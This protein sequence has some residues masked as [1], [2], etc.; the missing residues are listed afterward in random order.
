MFLKNFFKDEKSIILSAIFSFIFLESLVFFAVE[1]A[2]KSELD[3]YL[4]VIS[5]DFKSHVDIANSH[6]TDISKIFYD[7]EVNHPDIV[8]IIAKASQTDN[9]QT[10]ALL[11]EE[12]F[13]KLTP[14]YSYMHKYRVRQ[15]HFHLPHSVSFLRF[16]RPAKFGDSLVG[17]R[18]TLDYVNENR[19]PI[20]AFEE[21][22]IFNGFRNVYPIYKDKKFVGTVEISFAFDG[23]QE[24]LS[25]IDATSY[26]FMIKNKIV[27]RKVFK[28][29]K[30]NYKVSEFSGFDYDKKTL[31]DTM[32]IGLQEMHKINKIIASKVTEKLKNGELF[33]IYLK[34]KEL[35]NN[36]S[37]I[38]SFNPVLNLNN[39]LV[40]YIVHY[41]FGDFIDIILGNLKILFLVLT[42]LAALLSSVFISILLSERKK[43]KIVHDLAVHDAL[44]GIYNRHGINEIL[45]QK[46]EEFKR[47]KNSLSV[48]FFDIDFFKRVNDTYGHDMG[49]YVLENI[50]E[51][52]SL[53]IR[54]SDIFA[55]W[56]G[57]E[58]ILF[59]PKTDI[60]EAVNVAEKLRGIIQE[61]AFSDIDSI[62]CSFG[63]THLEEGDTKVLFLK[64]VDE[65]LYYAKETG[66]NKVVSNIKS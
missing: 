45:N 32:Q 63:V 36:H 2:K 58:F 38:V 8:D 66:R 4:S 55:R 40:A 23:M 56:G 18:E 33:S 5:P 3:N 43:Q 27:D 59:L 52:V 49:D 60:V 57:E 46:L 31:K 50:A 24:L 21:G 53:E 42:L 15:L 61:H 11:R 13:K 10:Q 20:S 65:L 30:S 54:A 26:I 62:T 12:L 41:E 35:Y 19:T 39:K 7:T 64:R 16:H 28:D 48:I 44:T 17:I 47:D 51:L 25:S 9:L 1:Y 14:T 34:E 29:E 6:L 37:I 22:R